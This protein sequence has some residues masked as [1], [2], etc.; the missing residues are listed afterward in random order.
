MNLSEPPDAPYYDA[1]RL[2]AEV[3]TEAFAP[4]RRQSVAEWA[5]EHRW[6]ANEGG[7]YVGKW[8][9]D[10][11][12]YLHAPMEALTDNRYLTIAIAGPGQSG[13]TEIVL[14]WLGASI[15]GDPADML[16]YLQ[17]DAVTQAFVKTRIEPLI[18][19]H[20]SLRAQRGL[21]AVD[22]SLGFKRFRGMTTEFLS[23]TRSGMINKRA[24][25]IVADEWDAYADDL[26]D[27]KALLDIRRQTYG[28]E[29][30]LV[31]ISHPDKAAGSRPSASRRLASSRA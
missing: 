8:R 7:G 28:R 23:A 26:G 16:W 29:S 22:D 5:A 4:P 27:P 18:E 11:A 20:P 25:R 9:H 14:N 17:T 3:F 15:Q 24:P 19:D 12:P 21:R 1:R 6:L 31:A 13:K 2:V 10:I 30:K